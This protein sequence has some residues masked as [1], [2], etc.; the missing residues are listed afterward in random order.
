MC[1]AIQGVNVFM[2]NNRNHAMVPVEKI[3][4]SWWQFHKDKDKHFSN[5]KPRAFNRFLCNTAYTD[6]QRFVMREER[7]FRLPFS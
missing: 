1:N 6:L 3:I 7:I 4:M 5:I 2:C